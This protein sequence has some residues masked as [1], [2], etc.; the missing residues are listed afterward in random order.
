MRPVGGALLLALI[1]VLWIIGREVRVPEQGAADSGMQRISVNDPA[2]APVTPR[3]PA[4]L[5]GPRFRQAPA[6]LPRTRAST[7]PTTRTRMVAPVASTTGTGETPT[8][9][10]KRILTRPVTTD[11]ARSP[12]TT[13]ARDAD[14]ERR[15]AAVRERAASSGATTPVQPSRSTV[16]TSR[17]SSSGGRSRVT[18][19]TDSMIRR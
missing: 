11:P 2:P 12:V 7:G 4:T 13:T 15:N 14:L 17:S 1:C 8:M 19:S 16:S 5:D 9:P 6:T 10:R 18:T 3:R